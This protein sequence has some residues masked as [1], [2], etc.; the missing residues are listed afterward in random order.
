MPKITINLLD[1][2]LLG[3]IHPTLNDGLLL[4]TI[5]AK[6][7]TKIW[8]KCEK[9]GHPYQSSPRH[10]TNGAGCSVCAGKQ[11]AVGF[12]D[13]PTTQPK[14]AKLWHPTK[15]G[16]LKPENITRNYSKKVWWRCLSGHEFHS[17]TS[18]VREATCPVCSGRVILEGFNDARTLK[19]NLE[20]YFNSEKNG[21]S[22]SEI[23]V[24]Y[25]K[26]LFWDN[27]CGHECEVLISNCTDDVIPCL[28]CRNKKTLA[29][30]NDVAT[31]NPEL[32]SIWHS[33]KNDGLTLQEF[34][35]GY[36]KKLWWKCSEGHEWQ[37]QVSNQVVKKHLCSYCAGNLFVSGKNDLMTL[38]PEL[39]EDWSFAL[40]KGVD[41]NSLA[42]NSS[43]KYW[44]E[45]PKGHE[46]KS[47]CAN[48]FKGSGC[49]FC[50]GNRTEKGIN[51]LGDKSPEVADEWNYSKNNGISPFD[52]H[53]GSIN[54]ADWKCIDG[55]EWSAR[56][57]DRTRHRP[58]RDLPG[59]ICPECS[60]IALGKSAKSLREVFPEIA[61]QWHPTKNPQLTPETIASKSS[62][63][64]WWLG[65]CGHEWRCAVSQRTDKNSNCPEC[66]KINAISNAENEVADFVESL[67]LT[68]IR[69]DRQVMNNHQELD[70]F[71]PEKNFAIEYNGLYWH[72]EEKGKGKNY[73]AGKVSACRD[74][75]ISLFMIWEDDWLYRKS[76]VK[77]ALASRLGYLDKLSIL[78]GFSDTNR[79]VNARSCKIK[80][81]TYKVAKE[82]H[83]K[84]HIQGGDRSS[85]YIGLFH[86]GELCALLN[87]ARNGND[88]EYLIS[89]YSSRG[90]VRGGFSKLIR[91][92][93]K[94]MEID[95]WITFADS[96][97]SDG[98]LYEKLGFVIDSYIR[99]DYSYLVGRNRKHK[100]GYRLKRFK[101]DETLIYLPN[102]TES[103]LA[104]TN[105]LDR[106][107]DCGKIRYKKE[108]NP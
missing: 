96:S 72:T 41:E 36:K 108:V 58:D 10:K 4:G 76:I 95:R 44:W 98:G 7:S 8:W 20:K 31:T 16:D 39:M 53:S 82:F 19:P 84:N 104:K 48:R 14:I 26:K 93:E 43:V 1:T 63:I 32:S 29:G 91:Y 77:R 67:G 15:N 59:T 28:Y 68:I 107:W 46:W 2:A 94:N 51:T 37:G 55:H 83:D 80:E 85:H 71:I 6:S 105:G 42:P 25:S 99:P 18:N 9:Y 73:H 100:F 22:Y 65:K 24:H 38:K 21:V 74:N 75:G 57:A 35:K 92:A 12:N 64:A 90:I 50:S 102:H 81:V 56:I 70:I 5:N 78:D 23:G 54:L 88:R 27:I 34:N 89:R 30:F 52:V 79:R 97:F 47:A 101:S 61:A 3:Q 66:W 49:P 40:N 11:V 13:L 86:L 60:R 17:L 45:C 69:N 103:E 106:V 87:I 62:R 33:D